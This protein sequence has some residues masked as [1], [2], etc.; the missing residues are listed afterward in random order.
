[1]VFWHPKGWTIFRILEDYIREKLRISGYEEIKTPE[2]VDR[3][4][5]ERSGH[6]DKYRE[7]MY[8]TEIDEEHANEKRE[9]LLKPM[10]QP[11]HVQV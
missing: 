11:C 7:N 6:W 3:K 5:W 8:I 2:V 10:S 1:M 9:C 4:L